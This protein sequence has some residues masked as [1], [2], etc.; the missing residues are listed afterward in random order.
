M[1]KEANLYDRSTCTGHKITNW[2]I[3]N[4]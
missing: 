2:A 4:I 1:V 3:E